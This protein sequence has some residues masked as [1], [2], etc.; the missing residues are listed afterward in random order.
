MHAIMSSNLDVD[1]TVY[2]VDPEVHTTSEDEIAVWGYLMTQYNLK[3]G[4]RKFG[5]QGETAAISE[6]TQLH[7]MDTWTVM[8]PTKPT[9]EV[10][11]QALSSL[12]FLKEKRCG[13]IK[14]R[15]CVNGAPQ[16]VYIPKED[17]ASPTASTELMFITSAIVASEKRHVRDVSQFSVRY[18]YVLSARPAKARC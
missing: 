13:K 9:R 1:D 11:T 8:D 6:L 15:A 14:G 17:A 5:E 2:Q 4:L 18:E 3:P 7:V 12:L 16:R 10:R